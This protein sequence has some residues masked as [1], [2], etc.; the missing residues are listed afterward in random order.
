[1]A[2]DRDDPDIP[3]GAGFDA[4]HER[5]REVSA[6]DGLTLVMSEPGYDTGASSQERAEAMRRK[7]VELASLP[8]DRYP[9]LVEAA[10]PMTSCD[11]GSA[12]FHYR[13]GVELFIAGVR[14]LAPED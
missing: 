8:P 5:D 4:K 10:V 3:R 6:V 13:F 2:G 12:E 1:M 11:E 9:R 7:Q 14:A